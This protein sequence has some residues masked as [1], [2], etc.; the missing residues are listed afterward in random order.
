MIQDTQ[1]AI[2]EAAITVFN[3]DLSAPLEKV[4]EKAGTTRRTL[5]RY[6]KD[7]KELMASCEAEMQ[8]ACKIANITA[9]NA[10]DDPLKRLE[11]MF[12]AGLS[13]GTKSAFLSKIHNRQ[14]HKHNH[15]DKN[16]SEYDNTV[17]LWKGHLIFLQEN[18]F[19]SKQLTI[20]WINAFFTSVVS[21]SISSPMAAS[22][23]VETT[24]KFAWYSFSKGIGL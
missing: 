11:N 20:C 5:H 10:S 13:C 12:Y 3:E 16:C 4:A 2:I 6:F 14:D 15:K 18:G 8:K 17:S 24:R 22:T 1:Q 23:D 9:Y 7:R 21:A 19:I